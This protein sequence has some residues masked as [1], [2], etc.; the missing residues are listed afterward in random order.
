M[1]PRRREKSP[2]R[3]VDG[4]ARSIAVGVIIVYLLDALKLPFLLSLF[5]GVA[6]GLAAG[7]IVRY[8]REKGG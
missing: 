4:T 8:F 6:A 2:I 3:R 1:T 7:L 5:V